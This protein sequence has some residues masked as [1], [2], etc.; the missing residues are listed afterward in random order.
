[1]PKLWVRKKMFQ[2]GN[3]YGGLK[4]Q[5]RKNIQ[6]A[7]HT[8][9]YSTV[10]LFLFYSLSY[11]FSLL[12]ISL[13]SLTTSFT[14]SLLTNSPLLTLFQFPNFISHL[15][16]NWLKTTYNVSI[17]VLK[18]ILISLLQKRQRNML[19]FEYCWCTDFDDF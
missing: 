14:H 3:G 16:I 13:L 1:M 5:K 7:K 18:P 17:Y 11:L 4:L 19:R 6:F 2:S 9:K 10:F 15:V 12:S 8:F